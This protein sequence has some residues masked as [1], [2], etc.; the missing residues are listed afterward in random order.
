[1]ADPS[2]TSIT[3]L[4]IVYNRITSDRLSRTNGQSTNFRL[5]GGQLEIESQY[6]NKFLVIVCDL[7][8][9]GALVKFLPVVP[10]CLNAR[11]SAYLTVVLVTFFTKKPLLHYLFND[12]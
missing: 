4:S 7:N 1:M 10:V 3:S 9:V 5:H 6:F 2:V 11:L 8:L 12:C